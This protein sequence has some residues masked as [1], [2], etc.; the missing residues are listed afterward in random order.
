MPAVSVGS[1]NDVMQTGDT[2]FNRQTMLLTLS[3]VGSNCSGGELSLLLNP[4]LPTHAI[5]K[6][7]QRCKNHIR[8]TEHEQNA[9]EIAGRHI[10]TV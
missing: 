2:P 3:V 5:K 7:T 10:A 8:H 1:D 9:P 4:C 6:H